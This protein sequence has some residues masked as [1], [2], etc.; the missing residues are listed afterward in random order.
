MRLLRGSC[1][2][3]NGYLADEAKAQ[4]IFCGFTN[5]FVKDFGTKSRRS[6]KDGLGI[7]PSC[8]KTCWRAFTALSNPQKNI[9]KLLPIYNKEPPAHVG[10]KIPRPPR[11][12]SAPP[13]IPAFTAALGAVDL[14]I[15][16]QGTDPYSSGVS[17]RCGRYL[18]EFRNKNL[19][20]QKPKQA[21]K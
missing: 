7:A 12:A 4:V 10:G 9:S 5:T 6:L 20:S 21:V 18:A 11:L 17:R 14:P 13:S 16:P 1:K 15:H 2:R 19:Y 3:R 8:F